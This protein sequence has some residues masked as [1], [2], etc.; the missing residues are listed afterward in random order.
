MK[1][2]TL[3]ISVSDDFKVNTSEIMELLGKKYN[4]DF[5]GIDSLD[6]FSAIGKVIEYIES[7]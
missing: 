2:V 4:S 7:E 1:K 6:D 3:E 5:F